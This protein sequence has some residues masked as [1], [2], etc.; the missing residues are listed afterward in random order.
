MAKR[1]STLRFQS[2]AG[3]R[4]V[5]VPVGK[6]QKLRIE[7]LSHDGR[8][9]A[10]LEG[11]TWF[12]SGALP[13]EEVEVRVLS[14]RAKVV[15]A[16]AERWLSAHPERREL[17]C[18]H[19][20]QCGGCTL[21][22][23]P[24]AQQVSLKQQALAEQLSRAGI[25]PVQ[26]AEPLCGPEWGY[27]RR[28]RLAVRWDLKTRQ[29]S[30]GFRAAASQDI[31]SIQECPV[32]V[33]SLQR[34][35]EPLQSLLMTLSS[36]RAIG[37]LE[38]F[39][40]TTDALLVRTTAPLAEADRQA[41]LAF[42][43]QQ[44]IQ[45]WLQAETLP[46]LLSSSQPLGYALEQWQLLLG[47]RPGDFI[48]VNA[49]INQAMI[50]QALD[51]LAVQPGESVLD[52]FCGL[53]NFALPLARQ[54]AKVLGLEGIDSMV[55]QAR[56]NAE[57]MGMAD[58]QFQRA[59]LA[60]PEVWTLPSLSVKATAVLL[61]PPRDGALEVVSHLKA[62]GA[63]RILY[64]SCNPATLARDAAVLGRQGYALKRAGVLDMFPQTAHVEAMALFEAD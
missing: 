56:T 13:G 15:E 42:A 29:L 21:Q 49:A 40:G 33:P 25:T 7:R 35:L 54:G 6:R 23:L 38:L 60:D 28:A 1:T 52:L 10:F 64:V 9:I 50:A 43:E 39:S 26:W 30:V 22:H 59:D 4:S 41:L 48:Q 37:H 19:A 18:R 55:Q 61:D 57:Q 62:S 45:L 16:R 63:R 5:G 2:T 34:L 12:V 47:Y 31:V 8:G 44:T 32:L 53:G 20:G 17:L 3:E 11:R 27:R 46:E 36:P 14:S 24:A 51:W 58:V